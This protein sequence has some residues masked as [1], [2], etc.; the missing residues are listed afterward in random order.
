M[1][2]Q[3]ITETIEKTNMK[4]ETRYEF[5]LGMKPQAT[6]HASCCHSMQQEFIGASATN[7]SC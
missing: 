2:I 1:H 4:E 5:L 3:K 7:L 6:D